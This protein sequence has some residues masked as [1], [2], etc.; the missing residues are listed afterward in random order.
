[1]LLGDLTMK[2][3]IVTSY[4]IN[5]QGGGIENY[6]K[7]L[8]SHLN[9][10]NINVSVLFKMGRDPNNFKVDGSLFSFIGKSLFLL[11]KIKPE[12][13]HTH[14]AFY[15]LLVGCIYKK[16]YNARLIH[17]FHTEPSHKISKFG[18]IFYNSLINTC[19]EVTFVSQDLIQKMS[20]FKGIKC[21]NPVVTYAGVESKSK[22]IIPK[23]LENFRESYKIKSDS[24]ILLA[25][26]L[27]ANELKAQGA[28]I[29]IRS[30]AK[31]RITYP[32][33]LLILTRD[34]KYT[35]ELKILAKDMNVLDNVIFTGDVENPLIPLKIC[36]IYTHTPLGEGGV[37]LALLEAMSMGKPIVA[38]SVGGIPEAIDNEVNGLLTDPSVDS[39]TKMV[40]YLL[41]NK[42]VAA[43]IGYNA[44]K[45]VEERFTWEK[46]TETFLNLYFHLCTGY[47]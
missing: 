32:N 27:T 39:I 38:T 16:I 45:T 43:K 3:V 46:T 6:L 9:N 23:D 37:S 2:V 25:L 24:I 13:I 18:M 42:R 12:V 19:D 7:N 5:G 34:A 26:G 10:K 29:L 17:T 14:D 44:K 41:E 1:M 21:M 15:C 33:I 22:N 31:L 40:T 8:V 35:E 20:L 47:I 36:D 11:K 4:W 30:I 28:K